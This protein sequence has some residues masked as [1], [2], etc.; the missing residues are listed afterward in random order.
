LL[1]LELRVGE[2]VRIGGAVIT[3]EDKS[4][5]IARLAIQADKSI[6][7]QRIEAPTMASHLVK[8]GIGALS[9]P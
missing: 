5:K 8:H 7:I 1:K 3:L 4:G 9:T 6:P 2:S